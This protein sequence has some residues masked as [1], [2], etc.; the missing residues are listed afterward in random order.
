MFEARALTKDYSVS[1]R[2]V[3]A[4]SALDLSVPKGAFLTVVGRSGCGKTTLLRLL[5]GLTRPTSGCLEFDGSR[6]PRVGYVFQEPRLMPWLNVAQN[7][8]FCIARRLPSVE[9]E[10]RVEDALCLVG[11]SQFAEAMPNELSGGMAQRVAIARALVLEPELLLL[12]EP[13]GALD[14]FTRRNLQQQLVQIWQHRAPT[15]VFVTHDVEEAVVLG[16]TVAELDQGRLVATHDIPLPYPRD[17]TDP[18]VN[19]HRRAVLD[20]LLKADHVRQS[21]THIRRA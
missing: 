19:F 15:I 9:V 8:G 6:T 5:S 12:D 1:G 13:F 11:L 16:Q 18:S 14:A 20:R 17:A 3:S 10:R 7:A 2:K 4:L 21:Q